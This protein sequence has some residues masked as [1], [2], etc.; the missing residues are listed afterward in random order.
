MSLRSLKEKVPDLCEAIAAH[1]QAV[2]ERDAAA[3]R[4]LTAAALEGYRSALEA[5]WQCGPFDSVS[6]PALA[7]LGA[8]Y[9]SKLRF[10]GPRGSALLQ[11]RWKR[12]GDGQWR[13]AEAEYFPP[14]RSP[15]TGVGR[16]KP[17]V[18]MGTTNA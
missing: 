2:L 18:V 5:A 9:I 6:T 12:E 1:A 4:F 16:P 17:A 8:H 14:G 13:I 7:R 15:W 11:L 10:A 3:E